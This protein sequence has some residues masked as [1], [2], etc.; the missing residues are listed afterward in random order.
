MEIF[1]RLTVAR[2]EPEGKRF[3]RNARFSRTQRDARVADLVSSP[4]RTDSAQP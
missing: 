3:G 1:T 4:W 2:A